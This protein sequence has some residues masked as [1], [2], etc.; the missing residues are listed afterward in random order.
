MNPTSPTATQE[1]TWEQ[2][3]RAREREACEAFLGADV[4]TLERLWAD[5]FVVNSPLQMVL[6]RRGVLEALKAGRIRHTSYEYEIET[7]SRFGD[8]VIVMGN[9]RVTD[10]PDGTLSRRRF[11]NVWRLENGAWRSI[12]RHAHVVSREAPGA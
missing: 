3:I 5:G 7:V 4:A 11:T 8:V 1:G 9:D 12:A 6:P 10:P 2:E